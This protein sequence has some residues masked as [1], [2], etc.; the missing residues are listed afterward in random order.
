MSG[1]RAEGRGPWGARVLPGRVYYGWYIAIAAV[2]INFV[3]FGIGY[4]GLAV[5]LRPL[6]EAH[7]WSNGA[8]SGATGLYF[9]VTGL[10]MALV[11]ASVDRRGAQRYL[12]AGITTM[13]LATALIGEVSALW[14]LY[15]VYALLAAGSGMGVS[16][17]VNTTLARWFVHRRAQAITISAS[18]ISLG[19]VVFAPLGTAL[20]DSGGLELAAPVMGALLA[21]VGLPVVLLF[22]AWDPA[23]LGQ[24]P[25]GGAAPR[26]SAG[27]PQLSEAVQRRAWTVRGAARTPAF[28]AITVAFVLV[29]LAQT[30]FVIHQIAFLE[31]RFESR[32]TA[33]LTLSVTAAGSII[34]RSVVGV[35]ADGWDK[36]RLAALLFLTQGVATVL[37]VQIDSRVATF[38]LTLVF[39]FTIGNIYMMQSLL[40]G[41]YFG[42]VSFGAMFG[43]VS[44]ASQIASGAGPLLVGAL[45]DATGSYD[46]PFL[47]T[48][49]LTLA[50]AVVVLL[51]R[52][53]QAEAPP[54]AP[55]AEAAGQPRAVP[56]GG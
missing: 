36:R 29:L 26:R 43:V 21:A 27:R 34:A 46:T 37:L 5:F 1:D 6:Q 19:G 11:G 18:G 16:V 52:T 44:M 50:A 55:R 12:L 8:V 53:P 3:A 49:G 13:A 7:D 24:L 10:T 40:V 48:A 33:A 25:D 22:L 42:L 32:G 54:G 15:L 41:E 14:Q 20:I 9:A 31:E 2:L 28:W 17:G 23:E 45:E 35:F 47:V 56:G 30:G 51:V 38:A 4:Y 39:G